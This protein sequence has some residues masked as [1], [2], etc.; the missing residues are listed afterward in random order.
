MNDIFK[1]IKIDFIELFREIDKHNKLHVYLI[2]EMGHHTFKSVFC[3]CYPS[4]KYIPETDEWKITHREMKRAE[5]LR[6]KTMTD[7]DTLD[8]F[9]KYK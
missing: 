1:Q 2:A 4:V 6:G 5:V 8:I 3:K 7:K 9:D